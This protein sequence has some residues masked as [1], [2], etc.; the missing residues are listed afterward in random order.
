MDNRWF[1]KGIALLLALLLYSAVPD[2]DKKTSDFNIP[3]DQNTETIQ[4]VPVR[5]YYDTENLVISGV[6]NT[7]DVTIQGPMPQVQSAKALKNFEIY[8]D[9]ED[10]KI[11]SHTIPLK[12][13]GISDKLKV[14]IDPAYAN[15]TVQER[16]TKVF[17]VEAEYNIG[18][19]EEGYEAEKPVVEP[20]KVQIT[21]AKDTIERITYVKATLDIKDKFNQSITR[22][23]KIRVLDRELNKLD[24][25]VEPE[26]VQVTIPVKSAKKTV[27]INIVKKGSL[28]SGVVLESIEI[29]IEE[30]TIIGPEDLLKITESVRVDVNLE[31]I[32]SDTTLTLPVIISEGITK[33][34]PQTV[35]AKVN[36]TKMEEQTFSSL[37]ITNQGLSDSFEAEYRDPANAM[38][39]L[40]V[41]GPSEAIN[42]LN[43]NDFKLFVDLANLSVGNHDVDIM[44]EGPADVDWILSKPVARISI[45]QKDV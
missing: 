3:G 15:I 40:T 24:V 35:K 27:P 17:D 10:I 19:L 29:D 30:A 14:Q 21:G 13:K 37:I 23:A 11:G 5:S 12:I 2:D 20:S 41:F 36:V 38:V 34:T 1:M 45:T 33:V 4:D 6:P 43:V 8:V 16:V 39:D 28:P 22:E 26:S 7:V 42:K 25:V 32:D 9:L 31:Q 18:L 44:V